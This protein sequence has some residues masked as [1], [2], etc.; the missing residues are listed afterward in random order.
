MPGIPFRRLVEAFAATIERA[1]ATVVD[2]S[3]QRGVRPARMRVTTGEAATDCIV[4][5]WT[6]TPGGGGPGVRPENERRIQITKI[7]GIPLEPGCRTLLGGFSEEEG[8]YAFWDPRRH[9]TFSR[10]SP[11]LQ[12]NAETLR[13]AHHHGI[14]TYLRPA[15][16]G[17]EVVVAVTP[18]ALLWYIQH[19]LPLHNSEG[20]ATAATDLSRAS[21]EEERTFLDESENE[22]QAARRYD[23]VQTMRAYR[24]AKF[25]PEVLRAYG[26]RC[27]VCECALK[28]VDAA[29]I[30]P[31]SHPH[32][33]DEVTNG[34]ALC[35][36]HHGAYDN[37]LLGVQSD[38]SVVLN[39]HAQRRLS[40][41]RL[42]M[43]LD[44]FRSRLPAK[45]RVPTNI[46]VRPL[47]ANLKLGLKVRRWPE[48]LIG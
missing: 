15:A 10:K 33:T 18:D 23:L 13:T 36:L 25:K 7:N 16:E 27:A 22:I 38:L 48:S 40:E 9:S 6:I 46:E 19:G 35:R 39:D 34:L 45:I 12:V 30:V 20:D 47:P 5:L 24:D 21:P 28:L 43:G 3:D 1:S 37:A 17:R 14:A 4:F 31:V 26:Y 44:D 29:H 42:D 11:S 2:T 32:S 41:L 8:V